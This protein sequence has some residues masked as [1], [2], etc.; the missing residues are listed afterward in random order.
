MANNSSRK[1]GWREAA[2]PGSSARPVEK[3]WRN[4]RE[5]T[6]QGPPWWKT[7]WARLVFVMSSLFMVAALLIGIAFWWWPAPPVSLVLI[8][9]GYEDNMA[10]PLNIAGKKSLESL[11]HWAEE[12]GKERGKE[13]NVVS[14]DLSAAPDAVNHALENSIVEKAAKSSFFKK[15]ETVVVFLSA[16]GVVASEEGGYAPRL[17]GN[18]DDLSQRSALN[19]LD[20]LLNTLGQ[21]PEKTNKLLFVDATE[22]GSFWP[23]G[24]LH[25]DF[26]RALEGRRDKINAVPNLLVISS[27]DK[28]Q[29]S[30]DS[31]EWGQTVFAHYVLEGLKGAA[32][33]KR[34]NRVDAVEL[35]RYVRDNVKRWAWHNR[36]RLQTPV[37]LAPEGRAEK[38][39]KLLDHTNYQPQAEP[40]AAGKLAQL[41]TYEELRTAWADQDKEQQKYFDDLKKAWNECRDLEKITPHPAVYTPH[42]WRRYL[43]T[44]L[45]AEALLR[46]GD[47]VRTVKL[48]E[49]LQ[50][51]KKRMEDAGALKRES[52]Q[53][54]RGM[55]AALGQRL[56]PREK[57]ALARLDKLWRE[58][59]AKKTYEDDKDHEQARTALLDP[60]GQ[61]PLRRRM[62]RATLAGHVVRDMTSE[63]RLTYGRQL[64]K[65]L[66]ADPPYCRPAEVHYLMM[67]RPEDAAGGRWPIDPS[68]E[69]DRWPLLQKSLRVRLLAEQAALGLHEEDADKD[70]PAY[71]EQVLPWIR[72]TIEQADKS[73][74]RGQDL[75]FASPKTR[76]E[77]TETAWDS[78]E[79]LL[80]ESVKGYENAQAMAADIRRALDVRDRLLT[81]LS[82][83]TRWVAEREPEQVE[84]LSRI[85]Q[86][87]H[88]LHHDLENPPADGA[89]RDRAA[90]FGNEARRIA[91]EYANL[92]D[93][94]WRSARKDNPHTQE[95]W[96]E[97]EALLSVPFLTA[98]DRLTLLAASRDI[99]RELFANPRKDAGSESINEEENSRQARALAQR[100]GRLALAVLGD[101]WRESTQIKAEIANVD[102]ITWHRHLTIA[103]ERVGQLL[104]RLP[105]DADKLCEKAARADDLKIAADNLR[106]A[107]LAARTVEGAV[108]ETRMKSDPAGEQRRLNLYHLLCWQAERTYLDWW[109]EFEQTPR[110][111]PYYQRAAGV[112]LQDA[113]ELLA[114]KPTGADAPKPSKRL[115][116]VVELRERVNNAPAVRVE[117]GLTSKGEFKEG[118]ARLDLT[119]EKDGEERFYRLRGPE[120]SAVPGEP[121]MWME[122]ERGLRITTD[123]KERKT[124]EFGPPDSY[125]AKIVE[126]R[127][128]ELSGQEV[129][130][131]TV[132]GF[133]RGHSP[134]LVT[135]VRVY[136]AANL[137]LTLPVRQRGGSVAV[138]TKQSLYDL[139][140]AKNTAI[141]LVL[142]CS[143]SM[144]YPRPDPGP[145]RF[146]KAVQALKGVLQDL[147][148][149]VTVSLRTF[150]AEQSNDLLDKGGM[151]LVWDAH[152]WD[153]DKIEA[154]MAEV[155]RLR[156]AYTTPLLRSIRM[157]SRDFPR[158]GF[159]SRTIVVI[160]DGGDSNFNVGNTDQDLK[161]RSGAATIA[162]YLKYLKQ[163][164]DDSG[165]ELIVIGFD[166]KAGKL[167]SK[168]EERAAKEFRDAMEKMRGTYYD[169]EDA[170]S[171]KQLLRRSLL[172][173]HF[174]VDPDLGAPARGLG[175]PSGPITRTLE[176]PHY[177]RDLE[178]GQYLVRVPS[179]Q[180][181]RQPVAVGPGDAVLLE[182]VKTRNGRP[183]FR[184]AVYAESGNLVDTHGEGHIIKA[185]RD[186]DWL[187]AV[188]QNQQLR[189]DKN[190][191]M[192]ATLEKDE[193]VAE[194]RDRIQ[195]VWPEWYWFEAPV[196]K[197]GVSADVRVG[198]VS[199]YPAPAFGLELPHW[200]REQPVAL[201][202][203]WCETLPDPPG[204]LVKGSPQLQDPFHLV[205]FNWD[206]KAAPGAVLLESMKIETHRLQGEEDGPEREVNCLMVRLRYPPDKGPFFVHWPG[207]DG[208][209]KHR[210]Y[211]EAGKYTGIFWTTS[212]NIKD[213]VENNMKRLNLYSV[214]ELKAHKGTLHVKELQVG[215]PSDVW[216]RP[217]PAPSAPHSFD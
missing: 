80:D 215:T 15:P 161:D 200:P 27:C 50:S 212:K 16:H 130:R 43:D 92:Q 53:L 144:N 84:S 169:V 209:Q 37:L 203:W 42:L 65:V 1:P 10:V 134:S 77:K 90:K 51:L 196:G 83:Y 36:A 72:S 132:R 208:G 142:D 18:D 74:R 115:Q 120:K 157:A 197:S 58:D 103:G 24:Q 210:F 26:L 69:K 206:N 176:M 139:L 63:H 12:R 41:Q 180:Q 164:F 54:T 190:L 32:D 126:D 88:Q 112:F 129:V 44:L 175:T 73:R 172:R 34:I 59:A 70:L 57:K 216:R 22:I 201:R 111:A 155:K 13:G 67:V 163:E 124:I 179:S 168:A 177:V 64:L 121:V 48:L 199:N 136:R 186:K 86:G 146:D 9:A 81:K 170:E 211:R 153:P 187:L 204:T 147:P 35:Y 150:G 79:K 82:Y 62:L 76:W 192:L 101:E 49:G 97:I 93:V 91:K 66:E 14:V 29:R 61:D 102:E 87:V 178:S 71:S 195:Q 68:L 28:D 123:E 185:P 39:E 94:L 89:T 20:T 214:A 113:E 213:E 171:L 19:Q 198:R 33:T 138:Q 46:A 96:H 4:P 127:L 107:V 166:V 154:R 117:M 100:Q 189:D 137:T 162:E 149:D 23:L 167:P 55:A 11:R 85:W 141:S 25:N 98:D 17:V 47:T 128:A 5:Q 31:P 151:K 78:A 202:A 133:F 174:R 193:G 165:I 159:E 131:H 173:L 6:E 188:L 122:G 2:A 207:W 143:G 60:P 99:S 217:T 158:R 75:L 109:A 30:W 140:G 145:R 8:G 114:G 152:K 156:P 52:L 205:N 181:L 160:T 183:V 182:L 21:L 45:R 125:P 105:E 110:K 135:E 3:P 108:V 7:R 95:R 106:T 118:T 116:R 184:K 194:G 104:N 38:M 119:D 40:D 56:T 148:K 191:R